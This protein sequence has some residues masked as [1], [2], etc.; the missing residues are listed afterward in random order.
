[1]KRHFTLKIFPFLLAIYSI[2]ALWNFN[3]TYVNLGSTIRSLALTL[4]GTAFLWLILMLVLRDVAKAGILTIL[5]MVLFFSYG[6]LYLYLKDHVEVLARHRYVLALFAVVFILGG[7]LIIWK[8]ENTNG[9]ERFLTITGVILVGYSILQLAWYQFQVY[10]ASVAA[11]ENIGETVVIHHLPSKTELPDIYLIILDSHTSSHVLREYYDYDNQDFIDSL[12]KMGFFV[13]N[14]SQS[15]YPGTKYSVTSMMNL[16][17]IQKLLEKS[18]TLPPL[19]ASIVAETLRRNGYTTVAFENRAGAHYD[20]KE[21]VHLVRNPLVLENMDLLSGINEFESMLI[22]TSLLRLL[23]DLKYLLPN[24]VTGDVKDSELYEHYLQ[25]FYIL[26]E[27]KKLPEMESPIFV[28]THILV[29]HDPFIF[30][31]AGEYK[32]TI[33]KEDPVNGYRNNVAFIDLRMPDILRTIIETSEN[34]PIIIVMGDHGAK[35]TQVKKEQRMSILNAYYVD[36]EAK[37]SLYGCITPVN[38]FRVIFNHYFGADF[39]LLDDISYYAHVPEGLT[40]PIIV[41]NTCVGE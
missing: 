27:L 24:F 11:R 28:F 10:Q 14:C 8:H 7:Y 29:P 21:D 26:D 38:T 33:F 15:N 17:Y 40:D 1:M 6:H 30:T 32:I 5:S 4:V 34:P 37:A 39:Q 9:L 22:E 41:P 25:T 16:N 3:I 13:A 35:G 12:T 23:S 31:P 20:L 19:N 2:L 36:E 18:D